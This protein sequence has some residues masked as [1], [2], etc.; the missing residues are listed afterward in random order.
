M[1]DQISI[2]ISDVL[3]VYG[4]ILSTILAILYYLLS[5]PRVKIQVEGYHGE[6]HVKKI[7][8]ETG[9]EFKEYKRPIKVSGIEVRI[10]NIGGKPIRILYVGLSHDH[11]SVAVSTKPLS[12][13]VFDVGETETYKFP[14]WHIRSTIDNVV[15][16]SKP[17]FIFVESAGYRTQKKKIKSS[18]IKIALSVKGRRPPKDEFVDDKDS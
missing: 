9:L 15:A 5:R 13:V 12:D 17:W 18:D 2:S 10:T 14:S 8:T 7:Q 1:G 3:A 4:A 16:S 11:C 6:E